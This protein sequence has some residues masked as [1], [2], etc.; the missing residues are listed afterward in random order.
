MITIQILVIIT[1]CICAYVLGSIPFSV[2][3]GTKLKKQDLRKIGVGNPGGFHACTV[4]G[5]AIG[6]LIMLLDFSKGT[7]TIAIIDHL[8]S[9]DLFKNT[10]DQNMW[11]TLACILGPFFCVIGH[12]YSIFLKFNG[13][14]GVGIF[15]GTLFYL[16]P[17]LIIIYFLISSIFIGILKMDISYS[18]L[19]GIIL[20]VV[21]ALFLPIGPPWSLILD[22]WVVGK[23]DS[24]HLTS[25]F[26]LLSISIALLIRFIHQLITENKRW[27]FSLREGQKDLK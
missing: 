22:D 9:I 10:N 23:K 16:N 18:Q 14:Q 1:T 13:G 6:L 11:H 19:I 21:I 25:S 24:I 7:I 8:F 20:S 27:T 12:N 15:L 5:P 4:Y 17:L 3:I 26:T 2:W